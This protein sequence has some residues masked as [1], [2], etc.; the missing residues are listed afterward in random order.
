MGPHVQ[1]CHFGLENTILDSSQ[2]FRL[3]TIQHYQG[4]NVQNT[5]ILK[6]FIRSYTPRKL[7]CNLKIP[8]WNRINIYKPRI[9]GFHASFWGCISDSHFLSLPLKKTKEKQLEVPVG[10]AR[11]T[12]R[13]ADNIGNGHRAKSSRVMGFETGLLMDTWHI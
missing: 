11:G 7:I 10:K 3:D 13:T 4:F 12:P 5:S 9:F 2:N 1:T 6:I 8:P